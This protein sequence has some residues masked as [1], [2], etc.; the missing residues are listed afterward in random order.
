MINFF[1]SVDLTMKKKTLSFLCQSYDLVYHSF[2]NTI[3]VVDSISRSVHVGDN[4]LFDNNDGL[5]ALST[6]NLVGLQ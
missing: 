3:A 4:C 5:I 2:S 6:N 1:L